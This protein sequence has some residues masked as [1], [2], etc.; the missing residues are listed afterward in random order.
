VTSLV[1]QPFDPAVP[2]ATDS[3]ADGAL[4]SYLIVAEAEPVLPALSV[5][6]RLTDALASSGPEYEA[7]PHDEIPL[8]ASDPFAEMRTGLVYQPL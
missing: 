2:A 5:Q 6:L 7:L 4:E 8:M 3:V 1:Y